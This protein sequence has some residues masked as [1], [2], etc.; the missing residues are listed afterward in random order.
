MGLRNPERI[1]SKHGNIPNSRKEGTLPFWLGTS[2]AGLHFPNPTADDK[3][4]IDL[5][6]IYR[7]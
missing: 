1:S 4:G 2:G 7:R 6:I 5:V 3:N